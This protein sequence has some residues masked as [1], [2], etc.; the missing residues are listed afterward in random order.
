MSAA[1]FSSGFYQIFHTVAFAFD[2]L[3]F[4]VMQQSVE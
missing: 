4:S 3:S 2:N 1:L